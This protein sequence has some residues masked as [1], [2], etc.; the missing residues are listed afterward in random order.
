MKI[1]KRMLGILICIGIIFV[2]PAGTAEAVTNDSIKEK[3]AEIDSARKEVEGLKSNLTDIEAVKKELE[4]SKSDLNAY[5]EQLDAQ[6]GSIQ[7]K[8][9]E[10]N[11]LILQKEFEIEITTEELNDAIVKQEEQYA[12]MKKR[13]KFMYEK[14]NTL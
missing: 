2:F 5:V 8:I 4:Q 12:A 10:Y 7:D 11:N 14:G 9:A 3:E 1:L 6:L 13:I